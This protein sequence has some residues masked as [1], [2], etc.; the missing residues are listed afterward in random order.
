[1]E[2]EADLN[3]KDVGKWGHMYTTDCLLTRRLNLNILQ[4]LF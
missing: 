3:F 4:K 2:R 1:M